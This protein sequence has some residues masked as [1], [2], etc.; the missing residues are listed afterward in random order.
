MNKQNRKKFNIY[1]SI[2]AVVAIVATMFFSGLV[3]NAAEDDVSL[4]DQYNISSETLSPSEIDNSNVAFTDDQ[5][6][7]DRYNNIYSNGFL[8]DNTYD[9]P[10]NYYSVCASGTYYTDFYFI[11]EGSFIISNKVNNAYKN[12]IYMPIENLDSS[13]IDENNNY[14]FNHVYYEGSDPVGKYSVTGTSISINNKYVVDDVDYIRVDLDTL[15]SSNYSILSASVPIYNYQDID[16]FTSLNG[17]KNYNYTSSGG[18][19]AGLSKADIEAN[20]LLKNGSKIYL[21]NNSFNVGDLIIYPVLTETQKN[22]SNNFKLRLTGTCTYSFSY[23]SDASNIITSNGSSV[24]SLYG[25]FSPDRENSVRGVLSSEAGDYIDFSF[26]ELL[27]GKKSITLDQ[28]NSHYA[29]SGRDNGIQPLASGL[30]G[31]FGGYGF[32]SGIGRNFNGSSIMGFNFN[33][34][35][36]YDLTRYDVVP[37]HAHYI[38]EAWVVG[39]GVQ[40]SNPTSVIDVDLVT[41]ELKPIVENYASDEQIMSALGSDILPAGYANANQPVSPQ[42]MQGAI[43]NSANAS[44]GGA[45]GNSNSNSNIESGAIVINNNPTFNNKNDLS[46]DGNSGLIPFILGLIA[47]NKKASTSTVENI[48]NTDGWLSIMNTTFSF[49]PAG[50]WTLLIGAFTAAVGIM[51]VSFILGIII[52]FIT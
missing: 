11:P 17:L 15:G 26:S 23:N 33:L 4:I 12:Y 22:N 38:I 18:S 40:A 52:K 6:K 41:G 2:F 27:S 21:T 47:G 19:G 51:I 35:D 16:N 24:N 42:N 49:V 48:S 50:V 10:Y 31:T 43:T 39:N 5:A 7:I 30:D 32:W 3:V 14:F 28:L 1:L 44:S 20:S 37:L 9:L 34:F 8:Y 45:G 36:A 29:V 46:S 25:P 13:L